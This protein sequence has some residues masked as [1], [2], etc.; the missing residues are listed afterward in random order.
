MLTV[1][2]DL[3]IRVAVPVED[4]V[5]MSRGV[6]NGGRRRWYRPVLAFRVRG[7]IQRD[8]AV[9]WTPWIVAGDVELRSRKG[10][11]VL[12]DHAGVELRKQCQQL[13]S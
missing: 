7:E 12:R 6:G 10:N 3:E 8:H 13:V 11:H 5:V 4:G 9:R 1:V 2:A